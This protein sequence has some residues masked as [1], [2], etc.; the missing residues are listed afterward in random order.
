M[1]IAFS[2]SMRRRP[3]IV[4]A[5]VARSKKICDVIYYYGGSGGHELMF[6][7]GFVSSCFSLLS[8]SAGE[9]E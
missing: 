7:D 1:D 3:V 4:S 8:W 9:T 6:V 5:I 2:I